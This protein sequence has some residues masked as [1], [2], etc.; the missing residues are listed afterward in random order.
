MAAK[1]TKNMDLSSDTSFDLPD[2]DS[3]S[4]K[5][6]PDFVQLLRDVKKEESRTGSKIAKLSSTKKA[7]NIHKCSIVPV[8]HTATLQNFKEQR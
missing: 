5:T 8:N 4:P 1:S 6:T 7:T 3:D 2:I